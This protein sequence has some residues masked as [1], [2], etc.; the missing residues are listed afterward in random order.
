MKTLKTIFFST[1][2]G[3]AIMFGLTSC[4]DNDLS[5]VADIQEDF[6][7]IT[8]IEVD[9]GFLDVAYT[10][11]TGKQNVSLN[12]FLK[13]NSNKRTSIDYKVEGSKLIVKVSSKSGFLGN[14]RSEGHI[15]LSGPKTMLV[16]LETGS[17]NI[18]ASDIVAIE[19]NFFV[20]SGN[21]KVSRVSAETMY[22]TTSSGTLSG[23]DL[24]GKILSIT[25]SGKIDIQKVEGNLDASGSS[26]E[27]KLKD[28]NG[29]VNAVISSGKIEMQNILALGNAHVSSG[30]ISAINTG[31]DP[32]T[33]IKVS[34]GNVNIQTFSNLGDF[35]YNISAGS[36][37][38]RVGESQST[39]DL[40]II[41]GSAHTINGEVN[42][43]N[44]EI[45]N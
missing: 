17:G 28:I 23:Q 44:I 21:L 12:A 25:S 19:P 3:L 30:K 31:L 1:A 16:D 18:T 32:T 4:L 38:I 43:G 22:L 39:G 35:N 5:V 34:S 40:V 14:F 42:S 10:G 20:G 33:N 29:L 26:G 7:N 41:N 6:D 27:F 36:G 8:E 9:G 2:L 13:A 45:V 24:T 37:R 15:R 11:E